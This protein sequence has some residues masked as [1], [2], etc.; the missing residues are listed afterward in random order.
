MLN[1]INKIMNVFY[2][3]LFEQNLGFLTGI[4]INYGENILNLYLYAMNGSNNI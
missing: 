4:A 1:T 2:F 3:Y